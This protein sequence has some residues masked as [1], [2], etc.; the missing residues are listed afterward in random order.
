MPK[1]SKRF[2]LHTETVNSQGFRMLTSGA[3]LSGFMAN[4]LLL[5]NHIRP[6]GIR[7]DQ[8]LP[9]GFWTDIEVS[10]NQ[11]T[12]VP[13]FDD[14]DDFA[15]QIFNKVENGTIKMCSVGAEPIE[16]SEDPSLMLPSQVKPTITK[17]KMLE[18]S[19]VDVGANPDSLTVQLFKNEGSI[20]LSGQ[21]QENFINQ[22]TLKMA[23]NE[24][25]E[26]ELQKENEDLKARLKELSDE[27]KKMKATLSSYEED[28]K[29]MAEKEEQEKAEKLVNSAID[30]KKITLAQKSG[31]L[32]LA[33][34]DFDSTKQTLDNMS[35]MSSVR[36]LLQTG[37]TKQAE[38]V[39]KLSALSYDEL[40][41]SKNGDLNFL[42]L[43]APDVYAEKFEE[44]FGRKPLN[45]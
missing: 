37:G 10:D 42:K 21:N 36:E 23:E 3:D 44:K 17:W 6:K 43:N 11:I 32:K 13:F 19:V 38:R 45:V 24:D 27:L 35:P 16:A 1:S 14:S 33:K 26:K 40:F 20:K 9:L 25:K 2:V 5:W 15:M 30:A 29:E 7:K 12:A 18:A 31:F 4:S 8:V 22:I 34:V 41:K 28:K 39:E